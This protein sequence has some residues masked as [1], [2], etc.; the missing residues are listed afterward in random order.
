[1]VPLMFPL[2]RLNDVVPRYWLCV[3]TKPTAAEPNV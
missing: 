2:L 3:W 1:M